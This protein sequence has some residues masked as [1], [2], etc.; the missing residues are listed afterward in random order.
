[1]T[2]AERRAPVRIDGVDSPAAAVALLGALS[3]T[4]R[5]VA[6]IIHRSSAPV[7]STTAATERSRVAA[8][9][10]GN[11]LATLTRLDYGRRW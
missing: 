1:M 6:V 8:D 3:P 10:L 11:A 4:R 7:T 5:P 2:Q 9:R